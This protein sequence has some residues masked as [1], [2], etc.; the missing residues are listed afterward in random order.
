MS[1]R[2]KVQKVMKRALA[3][4]AESFDALLIAPVQRIPRYKMLVRRWRGCNHPARL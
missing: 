3:D 4:G 1:E 2:K